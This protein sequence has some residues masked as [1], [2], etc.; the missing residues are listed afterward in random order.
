MEHVSHAGGIPA[1]G[2]IK[3]RFAFLDDGDNAACVGHGLMGRH[4]K[5]KQ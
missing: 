4:A 1:G 3:A 5:R 2:E